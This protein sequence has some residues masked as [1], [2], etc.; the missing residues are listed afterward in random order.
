[1]GTDQFGKT[2]GTLM[3]DRVKEQVASKGLQT[4]VPYMLHH[5][6]RSTIYAEESCIQELEQDNPVEPNNSLMQGRYYGVNADGDSNRHLQVTA[7]STHYT[8]FSREQF[9]LKQRERALRPV[10][11]VLLDMASGEGRP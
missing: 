8:G 11:A 7:Q 4:A 5:I 3:T 2:A 6:Q 9:R 10:L 1:M